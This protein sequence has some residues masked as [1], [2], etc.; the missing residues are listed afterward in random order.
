LLDPRGGPSIR[1]WVGIDKNPRTRIN[2][3]IRVPEVRVVSSS[4]EQLG[5]MPTDKAVALAD[6]EGFDLVEVSPTARPPVC[7]IMDYGKYKYEKSKRAKESK[8]KQ[9]V[10]HVKEIKLRP[11]TEEHDFQFKKKHAE[12]FLEKHN[13]VKFTVFFRG[14][15]FDHQELGHRILARM[16]EELAHVGVVEKAPMFEGRVMTMFMAPGPGKPVPRP[17][18]REKPAGKEREAP[19]RPVA[20]EAASP[21]GDGASDPEIQREGNDAETQDQ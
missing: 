17:K 2:F 14:R 5:V 15:E 21:S 19:A 16:R 11:K 6:E 20:A 18:Q 12:E 9:H 1:R 10:V 4:G 3:Q 13:K 7:R 8:K